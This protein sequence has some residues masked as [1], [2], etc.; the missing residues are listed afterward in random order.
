MCRLTLIAL[1]P[2]YVKVGTRHL[3]FAFP[4]SGHDSHHFI[5][6]P[7]IQLSGRERLHVNSYTGEFRPSIIVSH[8]LH[9]FASQI[10]FFDGI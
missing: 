2:L 1:Q 8:K 7:V 5:Q 3:T 6:V 4:L 10:H 9:I